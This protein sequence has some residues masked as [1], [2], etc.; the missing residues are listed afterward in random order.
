ML[1]A[2]RLSVPPWIVVC[3]LVQQVNAVFANLNTLQGISGSLRS[4]VKPDKIGETSAPEQVLRCQR[5]SKQQS[6]GQRIVEAK[7]TCPPQ[8]VPEYPGVIQSGSELKDTTRDN[9]EAPSRTFAETPPPPV[10]QPALPY[11]GSTTR[12]ALA[13]EERW[14]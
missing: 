4:Y 8:L 6:V 13:K 10:W 5:V 2:L 9:F 12:A 11:C 14:A 3:E 1:E 7:R